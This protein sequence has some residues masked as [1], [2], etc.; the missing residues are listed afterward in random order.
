MHPKPPDY[1]FVVFFLFY[2]Y[3]KSGHYYSVNQC[4]RV[5]L[6]I[7]RK[8]AFRLQRAIPLQQYH[9]HNS[10]VG[11]LLLCIVFVHKV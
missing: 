11:I 9:G 1:R 3:H 4:F 5:L 6:N 7:I 8:Y 10:V 2:L